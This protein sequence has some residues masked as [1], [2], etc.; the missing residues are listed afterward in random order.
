[1]KHQIAIKR[2]SRRTY[3]HHHSL[4]MTLPKDVGREWG[5]GAGE[6]LVM[7]QLGGMLL[8]VPLQYVMSMGEPKLLR[9]LQKQLEQAGL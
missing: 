1:M 5:I 7:Y 4:S 2:H 9:S 8:I 6:E 3:Q